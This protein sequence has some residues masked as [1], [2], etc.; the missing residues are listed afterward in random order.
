[1]SDILEAFYK[2]KE[3]LQKGNATFLPQYNDF[4]NPK[5]NPFTNPK[6]NLFTNPELRS[7]TNPK[8]NPFVNPNYKA[9]K[10]RILKELLED[11]NLI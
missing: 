5:L 4:T 6:L 10:I 3:E 8:L 2:I 1:M 11:A 7:F 9:E